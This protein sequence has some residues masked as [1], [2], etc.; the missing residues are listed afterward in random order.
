VGI[1]L[2]AEHALELEAAHAFGKLVLLALDIAGGGHVVLALGEIKQFQR[3]AQPRGRAIELGELG[4]QPCAFAPQFLGTL[5]V[6]PD[7]RLFQLAGDFL[8]A[9]VLAIVFKGTPSGMRRAPRDP[10]KYA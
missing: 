2:A 3:I 9:L 8:E 4:A 7:R 5:G 1:H 6:A 10:A